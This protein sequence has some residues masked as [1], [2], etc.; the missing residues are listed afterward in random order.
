V[1][2]SVSVVFIW[3]TMLAPRLVGQDSTQAQVLAADDQRFA[4]MLR[5]DT[6]ALRTML[7]SDLSYT[8]TTGEKQDRAAFLQTIGSGQLRYKSIEPSER[9]VRLLNAAAAVVTGRSRMQVESS[10]Q[11]RAFSIRYVAVYQHVAGGW[12]LV[13][14]QST[15]LPT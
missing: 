9:S 6:T 7:A 11:L 12:Q 4:A 14:W 13:V 5:A 8:H 15:R 3:A 2:R 1:L 10:G